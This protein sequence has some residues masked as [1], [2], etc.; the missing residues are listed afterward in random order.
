MV[1]HSLFLACFLFP[2]SL[3]TAPQASRIRSVASLCDHF[4]S[5]TVWFV[6]GTS[7]IQINRVMMSRYTFLDFCAHYSHTHTRTRTPKRPTLYRQ[8]QLNKYELKMYV[9]LW[10]FVHAYVWKWM[11]QSSLSDMKEIEWSSYWVY[12]WYKI[13]MC[14]SIVYSFL[15]D[16][17]LQF[18][19]STPARW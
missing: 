17:T 6:G 7:T 4:S 18:Y 1:I 5:I 16:A 15:F 8:Q 13:Y 3:H 14:A 2:I 11:R 9:T 12:V 10:I 19:R